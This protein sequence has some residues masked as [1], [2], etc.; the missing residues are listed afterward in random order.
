MS[1]HPGEIKSCPHWH[2]CQNEPP[3]H[4]LELWRVRPSGGKLSSA[5]LNRFTL[6]GY[7]TYLSTH[8]PNLVACRLPGFWV[9][10]A[11]M[12]LLFC[13]LAKGLLISSQVFMPGDGQLLPGNLSSIL[14]SESK[15]GSVSPWENRKH[16]FLLY[17]YCLICLFFFTYWLFFPSFSSPKFLSDMSALLLALFCV[18]LLY[19]LTDQPGGNCCGNR[20]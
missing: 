16:Q 13:L 17:S 20:G 1:A 5:E 6:F 4:V 10:G 14:S 2:T 15:T 19:I 7:K 11:A 9:L 12:T 8:L 3:P 18:C